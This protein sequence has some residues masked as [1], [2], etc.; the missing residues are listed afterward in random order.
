ML[1]KQC[2]ASFGID[3]GFGPWGIPVRDSERG[4]AFSFES[5]R[6][7]FPAFEEYYQKIF[8]ARIVVIQSPAFSSFA[9][10]RHFAQLTLTIQGKLWGYAQF[11]FF[12]YKRPGNKFREACFMSL[13]A[14]AQP[15]THTSLPGAGSSGHSSNGAGSS[16]P[17]FGGAEQS[18]S[19]GAVSFS[20]GGGGGGSGGQGLSCPITITWRLSDNERPKGP[21]F[22]FCGLFCSQR[23]RSL[24]KTM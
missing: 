19:A 20:L 18:S 8:S 4:L 9:N 24:C 21:L 7:I 10:D 23:L 16:G 6:H 14:E 12:F 11:P 22:A 17:R 2:T 1:F 13:P 15:E 5:V 3:T